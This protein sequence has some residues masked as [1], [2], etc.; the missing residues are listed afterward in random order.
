MDPVKD[1]TIRINVH[2]LRILGI[3]AENWAV[4]CDNQHLDDVSHEPLKE[5]VAA[6]AGRLEKQLGEMGYDIPLTLSSEISQ[7]AK[8]YPGV[9]LYRDGREEIIE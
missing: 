1:V 3:W 9:E 2:E 7:L 5:V 6:I 4:Q 8:E